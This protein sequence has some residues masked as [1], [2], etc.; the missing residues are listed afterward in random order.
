[1]RV[2][3]NCTLKKPNFDIKYER[4]QCSFFH[5]QSSERKVQGYELKNC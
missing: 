3:G 5:N 1:M 2:V 4:V